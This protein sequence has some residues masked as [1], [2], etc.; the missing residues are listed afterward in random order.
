M[1][2]VAD[3]LD[4]FDGWLGHDP[5]LRVSV[6]DIRRAADGNRRTLGSGDY[7]PEAYARVLKVSKRFS[8]VAWSAWPFAEWVTPVMP[9]LADAVGS[10]AAGVNRSSDFFCGDVE[11]RRARS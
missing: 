2:H 11:W 8:G 10:L 6:W 1:Q 7:P 4:D 3:R 5:C 9:W